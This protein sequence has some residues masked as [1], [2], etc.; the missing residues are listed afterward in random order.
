MKNK[1]YQEWL[2]KMANDSGMKIMQS[3]VV[4]SLITSGSAQ[5]AEQ[6]MQIGFAI[7]MD[8]PLFLIVDKGVELSQ[9]LKRIANG[10]IV[11]IDMKDNDAMQA[12]AAQLKEFIKNH[13]SN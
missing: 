5:S 1:E 4:A 11:R 2:E 9:A 8:K 7:L 3:S 10:S 6:A 12:A 13:G